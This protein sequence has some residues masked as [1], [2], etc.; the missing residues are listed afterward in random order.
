MSDDFRVDQSSVRAVEFH[1]EQLWDATAALLAKA[2]TD[3]VDDARVLPPW[4]QLTEGQ[5]N[6]FLYSE[7]LQEASMALAQQAVHVVE[8]HS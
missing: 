3:G 6:H 7:Q 2:A 8:H 1:A 5:R 4:S